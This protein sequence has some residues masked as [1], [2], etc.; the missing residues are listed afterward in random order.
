LHI[1]VFYVHDGSGE[2]V[3]K[4]REYPSFAVGRSAGVSPAEKN[5]YAIDSL[6]CQDLLLIQQTTVLVA[7]LPALRPSMPAILLPAFAMF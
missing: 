5:K 3:S 4:L 7:I 2:A 6:E 1:T